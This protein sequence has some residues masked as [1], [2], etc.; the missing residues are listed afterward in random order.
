MA[1]QFGNDLRPQ[2][3][4]QDKRKMFDKY[5]EEMRDFLEFNEYE[6]PHQMARFNYTN[7]GLIPSGAKTM[8]KDQIESALEENDYIESAKHYLDYL[9]ANGLPITKEMGELVG[10]SKKPF[11]SFK[12]GK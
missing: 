5:N 11:I 9:K 8:G 10:Y 2:P 6:T 12:G 3:Q 7:N 1:V 4:P